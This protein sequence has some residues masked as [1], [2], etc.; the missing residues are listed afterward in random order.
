MSSNRH[1]SPSQFHEARYRETSRQFAFPGQFS[2][3]WRSGLSSAF[4]A[5]YG[6]NPN[7]PR[8]PLDVEFLETEETPEYTRR[9]L[10]FE[11]EPGSD[12]VCQLL[13]P[14][15]VTKPAPAFICLQG[16]STGMHISLGKAVYP[17]DESLL[18]GDRDFAIQ[19]VREGYVA[20]A[21]EQ[22]S[23]GERREQL[24]QQRSSAGCEDAAMHAL[25]L[26]HTISSE[27]AWDVSRA[28]DYLETLPEVRA[29][30]IGCMGNSGGGTTT[31]YAACVEPRIFLAMPSCS[32]CTY[33]DSI[34][35]IYHCT[36][37][38][39]PGI[40]RIADTSDLTGLIAPRRLIIVAG[41]EDPI[42]PIDGVRAAYEAVQRVYRSAGA[43]D[44][45]RLLV[46][47]GG[48]RFYAQLGWEAVREMLAAA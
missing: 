22:R 33:L 13:I 18:D 29:D 4:Q 24:Q 15:N 41:R 23:F 32:F 16:H 2:S 31:F 43:S 35:R 6:W 5:A 45:L 19:A 36:D 27:R 46:G 44:H 1:Y 8:G 47:D 25:L 38:F 30:R 21:L 14:K 12:A 20:L 17:G 3:E 42:F 28:V 39:I 10:V 7:K 26:G 37:N 9:K 11:S 40:L 48:H 34:C